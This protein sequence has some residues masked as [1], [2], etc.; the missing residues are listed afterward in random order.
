MLSEDLISFLAFSGFNTFPD[1][2]FIPA[3]IPDEKLPA[4]FVFSTGGFSPHDYI[5]RE[6]P[7]FQVIVKGKSYKTYPAHKAVAEAQ[8]KRLIDFLHRK[9]NY[10]AGTAYIW[11]SQAVQSNPI[12]LGL[13]DNDRPM[14]STNFVFQVRGAG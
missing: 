5:P 8:A 1:E 12:P 7:T 2:G 9:N 3:D 13:D 4:F 6:S 11:S 10:T 14:Y